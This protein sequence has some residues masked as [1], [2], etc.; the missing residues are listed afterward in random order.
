MDGW[1]VQWRMVVKPD[2]KSKRG[3]C[4]W[5]ILGG[6][7]EVECF[8]YFFFCGARKLKPRATDTVTHIRA[9][10]HEMAFISMRIWLLRLPTHTHGL[11]FMRCQKKGFGEV[12]EG[13]HLTAGSAES[14][15]GSTALFS[16]GSLVFWPLRARNY[17]K[18]SRACQW[19]IPIYKKRQM[20]DW[21]GRVIDLTD[22]NLVTGPKNKSKNKMLKYIWSNITKWKVAVLS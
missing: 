1:T 4:Q 10:L 8:L 11:C 17:S 18:L 22:H 5:M 21:V 13:Y 14:R 15:S 20:N 6:R 7:G 2:L 3:D 12:R 19:S 16:A 9:R